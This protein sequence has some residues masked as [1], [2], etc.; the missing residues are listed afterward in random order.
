MKLGIPI[1]FKKKDANRKLGDFFITATDAE[2]CSEE[3]MDE[4]QLNYIN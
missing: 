3:S 2:E 4:S 1:N